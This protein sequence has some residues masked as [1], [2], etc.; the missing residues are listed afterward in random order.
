MKFAYP[1]GNFCFT[2]GNEYQ[3]EKVSFFLLVWHEPQGQIS[4]VSVW[5][6][7]RAMWVCFHIYKMSVIAL[8]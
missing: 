8:L 7:Y 4:E 6:L 1:R 2:L 3:G 5:L